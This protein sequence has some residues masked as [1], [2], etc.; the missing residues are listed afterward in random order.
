MSDTPRRWI[1]RFENYQKAVANLANAVGEF[2]SRRISVLEQAGVIQMFE[3]AW[4]LGWKVLRDYLS[5]TGYSGREIES[6][7]STVR[8]AYSA[9]YVADGQVWMD[10]TK[11]S[12]TLSH[13]YRPD[14]ASEALDLI[15]GR[16]LAMFVSL[17]E[18]LADEV[19]RPRL[20]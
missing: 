10:A 17:V 1:Q 20:P 11:L 4:D 16:Y 2:R 15:A 19:Q 5:E 14:R 13:E 9:G 7:V 3:I 18:T 12:Y 8:T 6:P